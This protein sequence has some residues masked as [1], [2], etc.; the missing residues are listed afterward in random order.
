MTA[1]PLIKLTDI[2]REYVMGGQAMTAL[3][4]DHLTIHAG[5]WISITG[6]SGSGK[7]TLLHILGCLDRPT[8]GS[9]HLNGTDVTT[10]SNAQRAYIRN[11]QLSFI[12]QR[13]HLL[14]TLTAAENVELPLQ[15]A[16]LEQSVRDERVKK[17][18][19]LV[20]LEDRSHHYPHQLSGG[21][22]QRVAIA[23][24][25]AMQP[26]ILFADE[27]TGSL[28][29]KTSRS[30]LKLL[31]KVHREYALTVILVTHDPDVARQGTRKIVIKDG[32][33]QS[34]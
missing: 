34:S 21:Q 30:I 24:A 29:S 5:E 27:P 9:Y 15:Y 12:F 23:R 1:K 26:R 7:T 4:V 13:F 31:K 10:L 25:L 18:L 2:N 28:D 22:Q 16:G 6:A 17:Y 8:Y 33:I 3:C 11:T 20:N 19:S 32:M 14:A